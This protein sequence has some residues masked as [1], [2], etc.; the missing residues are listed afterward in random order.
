MGNNEIGVVEVAWKV[1]IMACRFRDS[2]G[3]GFVS[4]AVRCIDFAR[5]KGAKVINASWDSTRFN[6]ET[7]QD[8][9][10]SVRQAGDSQFR[11]RVHGGQ[12]LEVLGCFTQ[13]FSGVHPTSQFDDRASS[14][15]SLHLG[16]IRVTVRRFPL[17]VF[18]SDHALNA[19]GKREAFS[20]GQ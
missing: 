20:L 12:R 19:D 11:D 1:E 5:S 8:A 9:I 4:D 6:S 15:R 16:H 18:G 14:L 7:L 17:A 3:N 2:S 13:S 10:Y